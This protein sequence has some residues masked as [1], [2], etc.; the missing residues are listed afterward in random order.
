MQLMPGAPDHLIED[1]EANIGLM[2]PVTDALKQDGPEILV[3][4]VMFGLSPQILETMPVAYRCGCSR[5][6]VLQALRSVGE[7][8][9]RNMAASGQAE[10]SCQ[11]CDTLY[12]FSPQELEELAQQLAQE[13]SDGQ[14]EDADK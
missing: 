2:A 7:K 11:F 10:V 9:L 4:N 1:L 8:E 13:Q 3:N 12:R 14:Q 6:R 5:Q